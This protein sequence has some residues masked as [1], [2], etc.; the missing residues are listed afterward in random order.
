MTLSS[1]H[2]FRVSC[3][4]KADGGS[5]LRNYRPAACWQ[6]VSLHALPTISL[7]HPAIGHKRQPSGSGLLFCVSTFGQI[8][9]KCDAIF[10]LGGDQTE[11][12][13]HAHV[14]PTNYPD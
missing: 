12:K 14:V 8:A 11:G 10:K 9:S 13:T 4:Q 3:R 7:D 6:Q 2:V 1:E 5:Q